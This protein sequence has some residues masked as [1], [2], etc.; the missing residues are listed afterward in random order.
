MKLINDQMNRELFVPDSFERIVSLVP[1]QTELLFYLGLGDR[2]AGITKFCVHPQ[3]WFRFKTRVGGT[4]SV[5]FDKINVL[6]PDL[7]IGN[8]E[9]NTKS[10]IE[11][12]SLDYPVWMSDMVNLKQV[13]SMM[14][15]LG[16]LLNVKQKSSEL[17]AQLKSDF[18]SLSEYTQNSPTL[19]VAYFIWQNPFM[20]AAGNTFIN[21]MLHES[22]FVNVFGHLNRYPVISP[23]MLV[24]ANPD[25]VLL[26]SEPFPFKESHILS[27][28]NILPNAKFEI[29]DGEL[30]SWYG[31]R[32]LFSVDYIKKLRQKLLA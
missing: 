27:F 18:R 6:K 8:K 31:S 12:L 32:L 16:D 30:F 9:E 13:W 25:V 14:E 17:V 22:G 5:N 26:S 4:K 24:K 23:D 7:I 3:K 15:M 19:K 21:S 29:V 28:Q 11:K 20:V 1:S 10:D 2:V